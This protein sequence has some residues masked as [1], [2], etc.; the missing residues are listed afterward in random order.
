M[1]ETWL[2]VLNGIDRFEGRSSLKTWIFQILSNRAR[3]RAVRERRSAP[4]SS[5][6]GDGED[7]E[8]AVDADR[9]R[10]EGHRWVGH[11]AAAPADWSA[12]PEERLLGRETLARVHE[13]IETLPPRQAEVL[14]L[15]DVEG[16][17]PDEVCA[18]LGISDGN[19][20]ILLHRARSKVRA[21]LETY[22]C[23]GS[24]AMSADVEHLT[25]QEFV[26]VL[27]DYLEG[28]LEPAERADVERHLV[29]C[30]GCSNYTEQMR[31]T[32]GLLRR[33]ADERPARGAGRAAA[34]DVP[35]VAGGAPGV[36]AYKFL[37]DGTGRARSPAC[38]G[39]RPASGCRRRRAAAAPARRA[40]TPAAPRTC[41]SG[42]TPSCGASSSTATCA[43]TAASSSPTAAGSSS[44]SRRGTPA[45]MAAFAEACTLRARDAAL[46]VLA[47]ARRAPAHAARCARAARRAPSRS[48]PRRPTP[49][50]VDAPRPARERARRRL[51][52]RR[53]APRPRGARA[54]GD[55]ADARGRQRLHRGAR[56]GVRAGR[57]RRRRARARV[58]G[59]VDRPARRALITRRRRPS[60]RAQ[61]CSRS[62]CVS[63]ARS[64]W[65]AAWRSFCSMRCSSCSALRVWSTA[66]WRWVERLLAQPLERAGVRLGHLAM[67]SATDRAS[68]GAGRARARGRASA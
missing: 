2:A 46:L 23:P 51:R 53:R 20:R 1:Q 35:R 14:V 63:S 8:A 7:D 19:Q 34:G 29:I 30:R 12:L 24:D 37:R 68:R 16:W 18:A 32:I 40:C 21:A 45:F 41:P 26:E 9:F 28:A 54:A 47:R 44:A 4:F 64:S 57:P 39:R 49:R 66:A 52:R 33:I 31:S 43:W 27:T 42:W 5:L 60:Q 13:A 55:R 36:I 17:S 65:N 62:C 38:A 6:A 11:W 3:T 50:C 56:R 25:C 58:A 61:T 67:P 48:P 10:P 15:R 59:G 22:L